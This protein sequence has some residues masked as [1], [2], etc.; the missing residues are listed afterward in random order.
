MKSRLK[1]FFFSA[2]L[3]L[4]STFLFAQTSYYHISRTF[5]A[6]EFNIQG[7]PT[8]V[9]L[10]QE[11]DKLT[12]L[13][14]GAIYTNSGTCAIEKQAAI[15][16]CYGTAMDAWNAAVN[17]SGS[18]TSYYGKIFD[19]VGWV[20][21]LQQTP[22]G[23]GAYLW[24]IQNHIEFLSS[25]S[26]LWVA[27]NGIPVALTNVLVGSLGDYG[28]TNNV[29]DVGPSLPTNFPGINGGEEKMFKVDITNVFY[30]LVIPDIWITPRATNV[31][32]GGS[33]IQYTVTGTNIPQ[34]VNWT[35]I[36]DLSGSGGAEI[37]STTSDWY[38]AQVTP[39]SIAT[40]YVVRATSSNN[41]SFYDQVSLNVHRVDIVESNVYLAVTNTVT[42]H[43]DANCSPDVQWEITPSLQN[44]ASIDGGSV[45]T[46]IVFNTGTIGTNYVVKAYVPDFTNCYDTCSV[47]I[48]K[49]IL[50]NISFSGGWDL[51]R[52]T[53]GS[54]PTPHWKATNSSPYLYQCGTQV[55]VTAVFKIEPNSYS[56]NISISGD[57][58]AN[59]DFTNVTVSV[60]GGLAT[61]PATNSIGTLTNQVDF[62][63]PMQINWTYSIGPSS[64]CY[65]G[66]SS[67]MVYV[68][69]ADPSAVPTLYHTVVH[70]ACSV[71]HATNEAQA[72]SN[73]WS[74]LSGHNFTTWD[75]RTLFYYQAGIA[76]ASN[77]TD[78]SGL[79]S[80]G[81]GQCNSW[82][83]LL[84]KAWLVNGVISTGATVSTV[85]N[86]GSEI[87][88]VKNWGFNTPTL[89]NDPPFN[90][91]FLITASNGSMVGVS[92]FGDVNNLS[93]I[94]GQNSVTPA[95]KA[96][97]YHFIQK[98]DGIY[99][100]PSY[101]AIYTNDADFQAQA[102]TG[103]GEIN[104]DNPNTNFPGMFEF[105]VKQTT[106]TV[107]VQIVP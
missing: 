17:Y 72:V 11:S 86:P 76:W 64:N 93:G 28:P 83:E 59:L 89:T 104:P 44:G 47:N 84:E 14:K 7:I 20:R 63:N 51:T 33:N 55:Q 90:Y 85:A 39:G 34:G 81:N 75:G 69:L 102:V 1:Y 61:Y 50:T 36:P 98:Y 60:S 15:P 30:E 94:A 38:H 87:F 107:E 2:F 101:G 78:V 53:G 68:C 73:T 10:S 65:A 56:G 82:R 31:M 67:N 99:Y 97:G 96:F 70:L 9:Q 66:S 12:D 92:N 48:L 13:V 40:S 18:T 8:E 19:N 26:S 49:V 22:A 46:S 25:T 80:N 77:I 21:G 3:I 29:V 54:Y 16:I 91:V 6:V 100:D 41:A 42:L 32:V 79:L 105:G 88:L 43:L 23:W 57:G 37:Q 4:H 27:S 62:W 95:E 103:F 74:Q 24:V 71:G 52:D 5:S 35:I 106:N 45:G 58:P